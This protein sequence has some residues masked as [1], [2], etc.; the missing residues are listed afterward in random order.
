MISYEAIQK[1]LEIAVNAPSGENCQ[2]WKFSVKDNKVFV[3]NIPERDESLYNVDQKGSLVAHGALLENILIAASAAGY[4][5]D[6]KLFPDDS[7]KNLITIVSFEKSFVSEEPLYPFITLRSTNRKPYEEKLLTEQ[8]VKELINVTR[9]IRDGEIKFVID[10]QKIGE[11][12]EAASVNEKVMFSNRYLHNF[13]FTHINWTE[14]EEQEKRMGFYIKTLEMPPSAEKAMKL[15]RYWSIMKFLSTLGLPKKI[16][17][18]NAK[19]YRA[20]A[21]MGAILISGDK[22]IDY[23]VAGRLMQRLWL[24][25]TKMGLS[26]QPLTGVLFLWKK[27]S[28]GSGE[29]SSIHVKALKDAY[30]KIMEVFDVSNK[31]VAMMFRIGYGGKPSARSMKLP[32]IVS[33]K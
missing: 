33:N 18:E 26:I 10:R 4:K 32:P 6:Y 22:P 15:F 24:T 1:V 21:A 7:I 19:G 28:G 27:A 11:L 16:A 30:N 2:P 3:F 17:Q 31:T 20:S 12:A 9:E 8:Q 14:N 13:F 25:A 23:V 29:F 5:A